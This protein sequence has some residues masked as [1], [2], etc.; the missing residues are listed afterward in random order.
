MD[1]QHSPDNASIPQTPLAIQKSYMFAPPTLKT[2]ATISRSPSREDVLK[3]ACFA[4]EFRSFPIKPDQKAFLREVNDHTA[5]PYSI[6]ENITQPWHKVFLIVQI[7]LLRTGWPNKLSAA[8]RKE[9]NEDRARIYT[10]L[11]QVLRCIV[12]ILGERDDGKGVSTALTVLRSVK[13]QVWEGS[14]KQLLQVE[15]IGMVRMNRLL[16][17]GIRNIKQLSKLEFY[18]IE[19]L[20]SRNP[21]F[22]QKML[23]Q[24]TGFPFLTLELELVGKY[25]PSSAGQ[26][27][28]NKVNQ[29]QAIRGEDS[30]SM[31]IVRILLG[32]EN[33][34]IPT[35]KNHDPWVTLVIEGSD[36][37]LT[38]F[39]RGSVKMLVDGKELTV[40]LN[41][42]KGEE[43]RVSFACEG[44]V[45]TILWETLRI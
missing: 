20:L 8:T 39:W 40:G 17:A 30:M 34:E 35:W 43:L 5:I 27:S 24:L 16:N 32:F 7:D 12:D 15:G 36:G 45:G 26:E 14:E 2:L 29:Q 31:W 25:E 37:R 19:R 11:E 41:A 3:K 44:I 13:S 33:R 4:T 1:T 6:K 18:H 21:P 42:K 38:W 9:L 23:Y 10:L 22:G 28:L